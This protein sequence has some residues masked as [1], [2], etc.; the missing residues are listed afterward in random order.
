[1]D[2][3]LPQ[4]A[5]ALATLV[6]RRR[7]DLDLTQQTLADLAGVGVAFLYALENGKTT[8]RLDKVLAVLSTLGLGLRLGPDR[9]LIAAA[10]G[11]ATDTDEDAS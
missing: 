11:W 8:L 3:D 2:S 9:T 4:A 5:Q 1:M 7:R 6:R 10:D